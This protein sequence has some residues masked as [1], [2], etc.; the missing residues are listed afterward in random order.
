MGRRWRKPKRSEGPREH[1]ALP[2]TNPSGSSKGYGFLCGI[3]PLERQYEAL[4]GFVGKR[5]S[6]KRDSK[7]LL[8]HEE[9]AKL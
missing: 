2:R 5:K 6:G 1:E 9:G 3:K 4:A 8:D 7:E